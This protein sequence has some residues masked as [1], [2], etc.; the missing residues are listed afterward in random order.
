MIYREEYIALV[1]LPTALSF[2]QKWQLQNPVEDWSI[3]EKSVELLQGP[4]EIVPLSLWKCDYM[5][6]Y[7]TICIKT[8][9]N[10]ALKVFY[11]ILQEVKLRPCLVKGPGIESSY[12]RPFH[13]RN[14]NLNR[15]RPVLMFFCFSCYD[16]RHSDSLIYPC[17][18]VFLAVCFL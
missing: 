1:F 6:M 2:N 13:S 10:T 17:A 12:Y 18:P 5:Q 9:L 3:V 14:S 11:C 4:Q 8:D 7:L 16:K 15:P